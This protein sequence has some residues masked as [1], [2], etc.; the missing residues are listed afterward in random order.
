MEL[1]HFKLLVVREQNISF[2]ILLIR[3]DKSF[4]KNITL[5]LYFLEIEEQQKLTGS[6]ILRLWCKEL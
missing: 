1:L 6:K 5:K 3:K 4:K 2:V